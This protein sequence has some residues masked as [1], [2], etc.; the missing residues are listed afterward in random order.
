MSFDASCRVLIA[1]DNH[2]NCDVLCAMLDETALQLTTTVVHNGQDAI[3]AARSE[4]Y[5]L[6]FIDIRMPDIS[7]VD[8]VSTIIRESDARATPRPFAVAV[9][10]EPRLMGTDYASWGFDRV[11]RKP[12]TLEDLVTAL[13]PGLGHAGASRSN[14]ERG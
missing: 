14:G 13:P 11:L 6:A 3:E 4:A 9:T 12:F 1:D 2:I 7:G 8:V 5:C 10:A